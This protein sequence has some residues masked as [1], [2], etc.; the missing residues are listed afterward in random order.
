MSMRQNPHAVKP[1]SCNR[2]TASSPV[3]S[4]FRMGLRRLRFRGLSRQR[5]KGQV[6]HGTYI[7][8]AVHRPGPEMVG[9]TR[10]Q[11]GQVHNVGQNHGFMEVR[12]LSIGGGLAVDELRSGRLIRIPKDGRSGAPDGSRL[13][14]WIIVAVAIYLLADGRISVGIGPGEWII[15]GSHTRSSQSSAVAHEVEAELILLG[16]LFATRTIAAWRVERM[17]E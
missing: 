11:V 3:L 13:A 4:G 8:C 10:L 2:L 12:T 16:E 14:A 7:T 6:V 15:L 9:G 1:G 5:G 17:C